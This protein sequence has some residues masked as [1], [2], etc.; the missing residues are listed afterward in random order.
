M[1]TKNTHDSPY[2]LPMQKRL[3]VDP[4]VNLMDPVEVD[5][6]YHQSVTDLFEGKIPLTKDDTVRRRSPC[7][8][9]ATQIWWNQTPWCTAR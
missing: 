1:Y 7:Y 8:L 3:F 2:I 5:L 4:Y 9:I 6:L